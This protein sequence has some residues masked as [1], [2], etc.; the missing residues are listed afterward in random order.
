MKTKNTTP[1]F[2]FNFCS[3]STDGTCAFCLRDGNLEASYF[4]GTVMQDF[5]A[6]V[7]DTLWDAISEILQKHEMASWKGGRIFRHFAFAT[8]PD[9]Y[10]LEALLPNGDSFEANASAGFPKNFKEALEDIKALFIAFKQ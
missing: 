3:V 6:D 8:T 10:S 5:T 7:G 9:T 1:Y 4:D 2:I